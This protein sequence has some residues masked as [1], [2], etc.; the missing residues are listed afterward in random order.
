MPFYSHYLIPRGVEGELGPIRL[1][2][3]WKQN[4]LV[5]DLLFWFLVI[6]GV[7]K[8]TRKLGAKI[9]RS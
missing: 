9:W 2:A 1:D 4:H 3:E 8:I 5:L 6:F 7:W